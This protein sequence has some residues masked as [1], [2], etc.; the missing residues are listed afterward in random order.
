MATSNHFELELNITY[1]WGHRYYNVLG[2]LGGRENPCWAN[3]G[4]VVFEYL[5]GNYYYEININLKQVCMSISR[6]CLCATG[7]T[8]N[9]FQD[10]IFSSCNSQSF[11]LF[12]FQVDHLW[13]LTTLL[14]CT[15]LTILTLKINYLIHV[16]DLKLY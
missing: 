5:Y 12:V 11:F 8:H 14:T 15:S 7:C 9:P 13:T 10:G 2:R 4:K 6:T 1:S 3:M 16:I